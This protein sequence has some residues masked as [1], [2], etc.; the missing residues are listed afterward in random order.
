MST[1]CWRA[2]VASSREQARRGGRSRPPET[3]A[4][5]PL[6]SRERGRRDAR[7][8]VPTGVSCVRAEM[9]ASWKGAASGFAAPRVGRC[10][11][12][13]ISAARG[14][15]NPC[16]KTAPCR[17]AE[18]APCAPARRPGQERRSWRP[19]RSPAGEAAR[20]VMSRLSPPHRAFHRAGVAGHAAPAPP[21][22]A[23]VC[24]Q[25]ARMRFRLRD[26]AGS[27]SEMRMTTCST[28]SRLR[29]RRSRTCPTMSRGA[30]LAATDRWAGV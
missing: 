11:V 30:A 29:S 16:A 26:T 12:S 13:S 7:I 18:V 24:R 3:R 25:S 6:R 22:R 21:G 5:R 20:R 15:S 4:I 9:P 8:H 19:T 10:S 17:E 23:P 28:V 1:M 14:R 2:C 27:A